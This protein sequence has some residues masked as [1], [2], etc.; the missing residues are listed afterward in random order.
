LPMGSQHSR[1]CGDQTSPLERPPALPSQTLAP[2]TKAE[3]ITFLSRTA[4]IAG[5]EEMPLLP[6]LQFTKSLTR[7]LVDPVT[8]PAQQRNSHLVSPDVDGGGFVRDPQ[9]FTVTNGVFPPVA[10]VLC[11]PLPPGGSVHHHRIPDVILHEVQ[12][13]RLQRI[14]KFQQRQIETKAFTRARPFEKL[15]NSETK[16][17]DASPKC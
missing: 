8:C 2:I 17:S 16:P 4:A 12:G 14:W 7:D 5:M 6:P 13:R 15:K 1:G 3:E 10:P 9:T 11:I